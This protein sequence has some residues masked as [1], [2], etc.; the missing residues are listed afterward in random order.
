MIG[1]KKGH[2]ARFDYSEDR[3]SQYFEKE[4]SPVLCCLDG[5]ENSLQ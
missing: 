5:R 2:P 3:L 1:E 4:K